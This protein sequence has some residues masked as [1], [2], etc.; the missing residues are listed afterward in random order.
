M[1]SKSFLPHLLFSEFQSGCLLLLQSCPR[2][3]SNHS[4][5]P[6]MS[7]G[8]IRAPHAAGPVTVASL[9]WKHPSPLHMVQ[10]SGFSKAPALHACVLSHDNSV[11]FLTP[12]NSPESSGLSS[13]PPPRELPTWLAP[14]PTTQGLP[15]GQCS[16]C[17]MAMAGFHAGLPWETLNSQGSEALSRSFPHSPVSGMVSETQR[18]LGRQCLKA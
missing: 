15:R 11:L 6:V 1:V 2:P 7:K 14:V 18:G 8:L 12:H 3:A 16:A 10:S 5:V 4:V 9:C 17:P 13:H